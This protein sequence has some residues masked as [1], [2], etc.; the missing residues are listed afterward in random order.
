MCFLQEQRLLDEQCDQIGHAIIGLKQARRQAHHS[1]KL[2]LEAPGVG[3]FTRNEI[4]KQTKKL[5]DLDLE[6]DELQLKLDSAT[7]RKLAIQSKV[8]EHLAAVLTAVSLAAERTPPRSPERVV[9]SGGENTLHKVQRRSLEDE[10]IL[11]DGIMNDN[12]GGQISLADAGTGAASF[13]TKSRSDADVE[14][15]TIYA[16]SGVASLLRSIEEELDVIDQSRHYE[17][18]I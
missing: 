13:G 1:L 11:E 15:I 18:D 3:I 17:N 5:N 8:W 14:S 7:D 16:D 10:P 6:I 2:H 12:D 4:M 9:E